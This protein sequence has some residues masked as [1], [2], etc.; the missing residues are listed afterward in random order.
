MLA[1]YVK[2]ISGAAVTDQEFER[3]ATQM[4]SLKDNPER[5]Q[6]MLTNFKDE[7]VRANTVK[8]RQLLNDD[9]LFNELFP[10]LSKEK[11]KEETG[12]AFRNR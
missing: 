2:S 5:F 6:L 10:E 11:K 1:A 9:N 8:A 12:S 7:T 4:P 3:L